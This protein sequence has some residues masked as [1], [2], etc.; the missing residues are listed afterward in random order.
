MGRDKGEVLVN[1]RLWETNGIGCRYCMG[2]GV[3][4]RWKW[5]LTVDCGIRM[6]LAVDIVWAVGLG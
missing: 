3:G 2:C 1:F 6:A 4:M 5:L